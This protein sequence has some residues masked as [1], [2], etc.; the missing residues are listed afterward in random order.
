M[1]EPAAWCCQTCRC[2]GI[3]R[4]PMSLTH[5]SFFH[6]CS[7]ASPS[8]ERVHTA[9]PQRRC[10]SAF[11][12]AA[13]RQC[14]ATPAQLRRGVSLQGQ[15]AC[16][17]FNTAAPI[18]CKSCR[19]H[20]GSTGACISAHHTAVRSHQQGVT[21]QHDLHKMER[22]FYQSSPTA[23]RCASEMEAEYFETTL[24]CAIPWWNLP[25]V[26]SALIN[27]LSLPA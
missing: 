9:A 4:L 25:A 5:A 18:C 21:N 14:S 22:N 27:V 10:A 7:A 26:N 2:N 15:E 19:I 1:P 20:N 24:P 16:K 13:Y 8:S 6:D 23:S 12:P 17:A 3:C 11:R